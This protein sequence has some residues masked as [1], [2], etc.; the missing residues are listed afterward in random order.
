MITFMKPLESNYSADDATAAFPEGA[1]GFVTSGDPDIDGW[2]LQL[3]LGSGGYSGVFGYDDRE[4]GSVVNSTEFFGG[5]RMWLGGGS[6][7]GYLMA[8][9]R[10]S[11]GLEATRQD[12]EDYW[13]YGIGGGALTQ[14]TDNIF[15][16]GRM[17]Y[18]GLIGDIELGADDIDLHGLV[19]SLG[20]VVGQ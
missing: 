19:I 9:G 15:L 7:A 5:V 6:K 4:Y 10:Y 11:K 17:M 12:S 2:S 18:E 16:D 13:G 1:A 3:D 20:I 8:V 14:M